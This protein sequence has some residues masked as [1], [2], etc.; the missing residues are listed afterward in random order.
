MGIQILKQTTLDDSLLGYTCK[1]GIIFDT[2]SKLKKHHAKKYKIR[3][4]KQ[5]N[6]Y[7]LENFALIQDKII[8]KHFTSNFSQFSMVSQAKQNLGTKSNEVK[9]Q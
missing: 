9:L 2:M 3:R 6:N 7:V 5:L 4:K 1:C 8:E